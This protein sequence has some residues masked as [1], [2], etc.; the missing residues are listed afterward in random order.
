MTDT[1]VDGNDMAGTLGEIFAVD[2]T[3]AQGRCVCCGRV[4]VVGEVR[5]YDRAPGMVARCPSCDEVVL[6]VVR[7]PGRAWLDLTGMSYLQVTLPE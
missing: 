6:R 2:M 7:A 4:S 1:W 5:V 3:A